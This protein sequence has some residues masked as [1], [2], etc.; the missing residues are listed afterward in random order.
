MR[1]LVRYLTINYLEDFHGK[2][3]YVEAN[4]FVYNA[5]AHP[6][7]GDSCKNFL[8][9]S[10]NNEFEIITSSLSIDEIAFVSLKLKLEEK[11]NIT[12]NAVRYLKSN[13]RIVEVLAV[14]VNQI[15]DD[16]LLIATIADVREVDIS[17]MQNYM[18]DYGLFPR[19]ALHLSVIH[20]LGLSDLASNDQDFE[21]VGWLNLYKPSTS[22]T[23]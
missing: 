3:I 4:I 7:Y 1:K 9:R 17:S 13:P 22:S 8:D 2:R 23:P 21:R 11:Y 16:V 15:I 19:D 14:E 5:L 18:R 10:L 12:S 6:I 20:R